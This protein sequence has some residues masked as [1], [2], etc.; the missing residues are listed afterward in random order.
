MELNKIL[1]QMSETAKKAGQFFAA[2]HHITVTAKEGHANFVTSMDTATQALVIDELSRIIDGANFVGEE[3]DSAHLLQPGYNWIIDPID[4]TA[5]FINNV[6]HSSVS[7]AL[8]KDHTPIAGVVYNPY[9][10][11][12]FSACRGG[13]A[14][15]NGEPISPSNAEWKN[16]LIGFG[17]APYNTALCS[18]C[19]SILADVGKNAGDVR[20]FASAALDLCYVASGRLDGFYEL[21]LQVWDY[22]AGYLILK[23]AGGM[24]ESLDGENFDYAHSSGFVCGNSS[25]FPFLKETVERHI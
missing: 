19:Y 22:A 4:G 5:N 11:E 13:G 18:A 17:T 3:G 24:I 15:L 6:R 8:V 21:Q 7:I 12:L 10:D 14:F 2:P 23:E 16:A 25:V 1:A 9:L 20:R